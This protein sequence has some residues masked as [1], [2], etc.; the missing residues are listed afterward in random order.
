MY[1]KERICMGNVYGKEICMGKKGYVMYVCMYVCMYVS[2]RTSGLI[3]TRLKILRM[4]IYA[5]F[6]E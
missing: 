5:L 2:L 3:L 4:L 1:G 6:I